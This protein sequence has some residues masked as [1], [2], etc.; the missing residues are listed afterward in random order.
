V[1]REASFRNHVYEAYDNQ[2]A[3]T[4]LR[5]IDANG[6]SEVHA[7]HIWAVADGG[8]DVVQNGLALTATVHWLFDRYFISI[9]DDYHL[10]FSA[11]EMPEEVRA[12]LLQNGGKLRLP[13]ET[14]HWPHPA[15][16]KKHRDKFVAMNGDQA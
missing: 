12:L 7:A 1:I 11:R 16:L 15:Y 3:A 8:P 2:C 10:L 5:F 6:N 13:S 9:T 4:G 14:D